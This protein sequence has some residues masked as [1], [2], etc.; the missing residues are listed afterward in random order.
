VCEEA[1]EQD[2]DNDMAQVYGS[3]KNMLGIAAMA[4]VWAA[5]TGCATGRGDLA[6][7]SDWMTGSFSSAAQHEAD[8][9]NYHHIT[10]H[11]TPIWE[12]RDD[13]PWLYVEQAVASRPDRP[14]R[15]RV[16]HL[17]DNADG[18]FTSFVHTL[19][20]DPLDYVG[21]WQDAAMF[22]AITPD[23]L[24]VRDGCGITLSKQADGTY[25]GSTHDKDCGSTLHGA[26]YATSEVVV[27]PDTL[28]SWDRGFDADDEQVWGATEGGYVFV[29][30]D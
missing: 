27:R 1:Y 17:R 23:D 20:G 7:L 9:D 13:G 21:G 18:S 22:D 10:L 11:M 6:Q 26:A 4:T 29:K 28:I 12:S 24:A 15:Q 14:Y 30:E 3:W 8:P 16:Y 19:P 2:K 25:A 5:C